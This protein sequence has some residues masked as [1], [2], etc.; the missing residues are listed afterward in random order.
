MEQ[1]IL[2]D[3]LNVKEEEYPNANDY[4]KNLHGLNGW[5]AFLGFS[6][7]LSA[8]I[9]IILNG[10]NYWPLITNINLIIPAYKIWIGLEFT[11][12]VILV[13]IQLYLLYLY[14]NKKKRFILM[15]KIYLAYYLL[16]LITD[17]FLIVPMVGS[18]PNILSMLRPVTYVVIWGFYIFNS[19]QVKH[20]FLYE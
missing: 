16:F 8:L 10:R 15:F 5:L 1:E 20:T 11:M 19:K 18:K 13:A 12:I 4:D 9:S 7:I 2:D 14:F 3:S 6:I 17:Q